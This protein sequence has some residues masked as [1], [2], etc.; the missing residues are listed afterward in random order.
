M[1]GAQPLASDIRRT[2]RQAFPHEHAASREI[3][4]TNSMNSMNFLEFHLL[5]R[6][7]GLDISQLIQ[8]RFR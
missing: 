4:S 1:L 8:H 5:H 6:Y 2:E 7:H 3:G